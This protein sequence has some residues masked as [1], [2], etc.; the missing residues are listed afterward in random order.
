MELCNKCVQRNDE[1]C[2]AYYLRKQPIID[3]SPRS[4][5][6]GPFPWKERLDLV[7]KGL[8]LEFRNVVISA[9]PADFASTMKLLKDLDAN[10]PKKDSKRNS[11]GKA[12]VD[13]SKLSTASTSQSNQSTKTK[14]KGRR[15]KGGKN[16][17]S[18]KDVKTSSKP[19]KDKQKDTWHCGMC[20]A[21]HPKGPNTCPHPDRK[22][23][24]AMS[25]SFKPSPKKGGGKSKGRDT[26]HAVASEGEDNGEEADGFKNLTTHCQTE[27]EGEAST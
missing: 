17:S 1:T 15:G 12:N 14:G 26:T 11:V 18:N 20:Q 23:K 5:N 6:D 9:S 13:D 10:D 4:E 2:V 19:A 21:E 22:K 25:S 27:E 16:F 24:E 8:L 7:I 3:Q